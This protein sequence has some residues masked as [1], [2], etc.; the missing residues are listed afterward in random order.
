MLARCLGCFLVIVITLSA[1]VWACEPC[2]LDYQLDLS[3]SIA[4]ADIIAV[5]QR[6]YDSFESERPE[7]ISLRVS[8]LLK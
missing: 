1:S 4:E 7:T 3:G 6:D 8:S 2:P 5:V